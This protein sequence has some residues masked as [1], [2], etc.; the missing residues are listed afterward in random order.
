MDQVQQPD[1]A[2]CNYKSAVLI[3]AKL[4]QS[5]HNKSTT[6]PPSASINKGRNVNARWYQRSL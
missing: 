3:E 4:T 5:S 6:N 2:T 1:I